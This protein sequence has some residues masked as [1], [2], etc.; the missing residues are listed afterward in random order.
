MG[1]LTS[2]V[3]G[4]VAAA[5]NVGGGGLGSSDGPLR[6]FDFELHV[7]A[8]DYQDI[9]GHREGNRVR[10]R[11]KRNKEVWF[12]FAIP[13]P[14]FNVSDTAPESSRAR[15][16]RVFVMWRTEG[17]TRVCHVDGYDGARARVVD[18]DVIDQDMH[19]PCADGVFDGSPDQPGTDPKLVDTTNSFAALDRPDI[20]YGLGLSV[21][22]RFSPENDHGIV[23]FTSAGADFLAP[24]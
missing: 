20:F 7:D 9:V 10:F 2:W 15:L 1:R 4:Y 13:T 12:H 6:N 21:L 16:D 23:W 22:V 8:H 19:H 14:P 5:Q 18:A 3:P 17:G 11:G 24:V